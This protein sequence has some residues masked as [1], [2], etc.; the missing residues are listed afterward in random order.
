MIRVWFVFLIVVFTFFS[1][2]KKITDEQFE[3]EVLSQIFLKVVDSTY[4]DYRSYTS[5][6]EIGEDMYDKDGKWI[7]RKLIGQHE[8][9]TK[10]EAKMEA[11]KKDT[12]NLIIA[13]GKGG[14]I[15]DITILQ[16]Y[17]SRKFTFKHLSE[18][19]PSINFK[20]WTAKYAKFAGVLSF[21]NIKFDVSKENGTLDVSY[22]CGDRCGLGYIV[23][24]KK[25]DHKWLISRVEDTWIS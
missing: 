21:S 6:P 19:P 22:Y 13:I 4:K 25:V 8:R 24:I 15:N 3:E 5:S 9:D 23:T 20:N 12:L 14:L 2:E 17:N 10:H 18:L 7:G 11:F 1:C 16:N